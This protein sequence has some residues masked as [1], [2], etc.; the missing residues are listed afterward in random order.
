[1]RLIKDE[2]EIE[3][4]RQSAKIGA[5]GVIA[6]MKA[7]KIGSREDEIK[8][9]IYSVY[10]KYQSEWSFMPIVG[11]GFNSAFVHYESNENA[12]IKD[13]DLVLM[14]VGSIR[15]FY[16]SDISRTVPANGKFTNEQKEIYQI[17][18]DT[19][20]KCIEM[21]KTGVSIKQI[22]DYSLELI[23][24]AGYGKYYTH[25][26]GHYL[27]M[28][29][30]D[31]GFYDIPLEDGMITT[32]EPGIYIPEKNIGVRIEDDVLVTKTGCEVLSK[33]AP[34]EVD[35]IEKIMRR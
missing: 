23:T 34:K 35:E 8:S 17:V 5:E 21:V 19:Q 30:H 15:D 22:H 31:V 3:M 14:D 32:I 6:G 33:D 20:E 1:M 24:K 7:I 12:E 16:A 4:M 29:V 27:G 26:V 13:G 10:R 9:V 18:L 28:D 2:Y 25:G 11:T